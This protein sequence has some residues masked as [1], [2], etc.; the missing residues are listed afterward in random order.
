MT[1]A[2][3]P[4]DRRRFLSLLSLAGLGGASAVAAQGTAKS[5][6][7]AMVADAEK[8]AGLA[9]TPPQRELMVDG[10]KA[11]LDRYDAL[12]ALEMP[13]D[14]APA[15]RFDPIIPGVEV[16]LEPEQHP[17]VLGPQVVPAVPADLEQLAFLPLT[18][19]GELVRRRLVSSVDLTTMYL[20]RLKQYDPVLHCVITL[21]E[22]LAMKQ[23]RR[24]DEEIANGRYRGPLHGIPWGAKDLLAT[25]QYRTTWGALP[26]KDQVIDEDA[27][28]VQRLEEGGAVLVA[29]LSMGETARTE[30][31]FGGMTRNPW[32]LQQGA[33]GSSSGPA[34]ATAAGLVGFSIGS[35]TRGS[36]VLPC[37]RCGASGL[38]PTFGTVSRHG[39]MALSWTMDK[40]GPI[41]RTVEDCVV[42][43]HAIRGPDGKDAT[44]RSV[45]FNWNGSA[46]LAGLRV[47]F[48]ESAFERTRRAKASDDETLRT[49]RGLDVNLV[50]IEMP[51]FP[52][53]A[54]RLIM[55]SEAAAVFDE[56]VVSGRADLLAGQ[57]KGDRPN[58]LRHGELIP[59]AQ[60]IQ[61]SRARTVLMRK[62]A[63]V[64]R[65]VDVFVAPSLSEA[66]LMLTNLTGHPCVV[67]PNGF[68]DA[69][70]PTSITFVGGLFKD[71]HAA[72]L[73]HRYQQAT[74]FHRRHPDVANGARR[75]RP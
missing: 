23:A 6:S 40:L 1:E 71:A 67:V 35:D 43:L 28:V 26:Y 60:Y 16:D 58:N 65:G 56:L 24:A 39:A 2:A 31:W 27:T 46:S 49:L 19:L 15:F 51:E 32:N 34:A 25:R 47:G 5:V 42:V 4:L 13:N 18:Q 22:E 17:L 63:E 48:L 66:V 53:D 57:G 21:C 74:D 62:V 37:D 9:F 64:L 44:V 70:Q 50:P 8:V 12:R 55:D 75:P 20:S 73:A 68:L 30:T 59:A 7:P 69:A 72:L 61:A 38:R 54:L 29:K 33:Q 11:N 36:I 10:V 41:C 52:L 45:P 14:I 3:N